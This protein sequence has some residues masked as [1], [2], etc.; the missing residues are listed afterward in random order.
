MAGAAAATARNSR[1]KLRLKARM[2]LRI[3][4]CA[5]RTMA[6]RRSIFRVVVGFALRRLRC[7]C[8]FRA[9]VLSLGVELQL[10]LVRRERSEHHVNVSADQFGIGIWMTRA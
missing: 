3:K 7:L 4:R 8:G 2:V 6:R 1:P 10:A 5:L 9:G